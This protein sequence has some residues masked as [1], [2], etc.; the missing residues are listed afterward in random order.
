MPANSFDP[1][2]TGKPGGLVKLMAALSSIY[3]CLMTVIFPLYAPTGHKDIGRHKWNFFSIS[4]I[5]FIAIML[6]L[7]LARA[8]KYFISE[9]KR[10]KREQEEED[11]L[12]LDMAA[13]RAKEEQ[14]RINNIPRYYK[15]RTILVKPDSTTAEESPVPVKSDT[16][17]TEESPVPGQSDVQTTEENPAPGQSDAQTTEENSVPGQAEPRPASDAPAPIDYRATAARIADKYGS[18]ADK[19]R[20]RAAKA[21]LNRLDLRAGGTKITMFFVVAYIIVCLISTF[22]AYDRSTAVLGFRDWY[23]GLVAQLSFAF[24]YILLSGSWRFKKPVFITAMAGSLIVFV[25]GLLNRFR[26]D[27]LGFYSDRTDKQIFDYLSTIGQTSHYSSY[28]CL[29]IPLAIIGYCCGK[30]LLPRLFCALAMVVGF[31]TT[32]T[33]NSDSAYF[34]LAAYMVVLTFVAFEQR[35]IF[36][37]YIEV[38]LLCMVSF[39]A[40][41]F[42]FWFYPAIADKMDGISIF[43]SRSI[44]T[45]IVIGV[46]VMI[47]IILAITATRESAHSHR[48]VHNR[49]PDYDRKGLH[50]RNRQGDGASIRSDRFVL[51]PLRW[52]VLAVFIIGIAGGV[53]YVVLN[54]RGDLPAEYS[55]DNNYLYFDDGWGN[56]RGIDWRVAVESYI[57]EPP[58]RKV[59]GAGPDC[60]AYTVYKYYNQELK[61]ELDGLT[62]QNCHNEWLNSL[63]N[64]G[65]LGAAAYIG[66]FISIFAAC[67]KRGRKVYWLYGV[68]MSIAAYM[69]HN[70]FCYQSVTCTPQIFI[71]MGMAGAIIRQIETGRNI[72]KTSGKTI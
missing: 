40:M 6:V 37:R 45:W 43:L 4:A 10:L 71:L 2:G 64:T 24:I 70:F 18:N 60:F 41:G 52:L 34:A 33:Q 23:M 27:P 26:I 51:S 30:K 46:L 20:F 66:I 19:G 48:P 55:S 17:I 9:R 44:V 53:T 68:A 61:R 72:W 49:K 11:A 57:Q 15:K 31:M 25:L 54:T 62:L 36:S 50:N 59:I 42:A 7:G 67:M 16:Q 12:F 28:I 22:F 35:W 13:K 63:I 21:L 69:A 1:S 65:V 39:K 58:L 5:T 47:R 8:V 32:V 56:H 29:F 14:E 3:I 38:L